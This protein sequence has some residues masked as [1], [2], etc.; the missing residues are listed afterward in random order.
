[1]MNRLRWPHCGVLAWL[2]AGCGLLGGAPPAPRPR[3][4]EPPTKAFTDD[5]TVRDS[6]LQ[7][8]DRRA[9]PPAEYGL[10]T[11]LLARS[12]D[13][14]T[15]RVL[16]DL[17]ATT[18]AAG[19]AALPRR[20]LNLVLL[21]VRQAGEANDLL[22]TARRDP[23]AAAATL[24]RLHYDHAQAIAW[25]TNIC[26]RDRG[27]DVMRVCGSTTPDG[28]L[29][30]TTLQPPRDGFAPGQ[31]MLIVNLGSARPEA[32]REVLAAYRRQ[33]QEKDFTDRRH[34]DGWRL[35]ALDVMLEAAH[36]L[37]GM[38]KALAGTK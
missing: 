31:R 20:N 5:A 17:M 28:P 26:R 6:V 3:T 11:L 29:L 23:G 8:I 24:M 2:L 15:L 38:S 25:L 35:A 12:A 7:A 22:A 32:M 33:I 9:A 18:D 21:P 16:A 30:V 10:Y 4:A 37:P 34:L 27:A 1:M 19:A 36:M 13:R 14:T